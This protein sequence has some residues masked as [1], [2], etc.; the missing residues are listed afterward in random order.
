MED[1][2]QNSFL[3]RF[4]RCLQFAV[5]PNSQQPA[6]CVGETF[7]RVRNRWDLKPFFARIVFAN[8]PHAGLEAAL[9][10]MRSRHRT[11]STLSSNSECKALQSRTLLARACVERHVGCWGVV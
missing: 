10:L 6:I 8:S 7:F 9:D 4:F 1:H 5:Q 3:T 2:A 11:L